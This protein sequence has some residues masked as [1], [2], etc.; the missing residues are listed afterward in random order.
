M[1]TIFAV[2]KPFTGHI[3]IIQRNAIHSWSRLHPRVEVILCGDE[4]GTKEMADEVHA[5]YLPQVARNQYGT[6]L[7]DSVFEQAERAAHSRLMCY[8]NADVVLLG[9]FATAMQRIGFPRFL[10]VGQ[11][12]DVD[13]T[14][15]WDFEQPDWE[16]GFRSLVA[17]RGRLHPPM[18]SDYFVFPRNRGVATLPPFAVGRPGWDNWFIYHARRHRV[19]VIDVTRVVTVIHQNHGYDHVPERRDDT[20]EGPEADSNRSLVGPREHVYVLSDASHV[21]TPRW[22]MPTVGLK[23]KRLA[24]A[25]IQR[26]RRSPSLSR[27]YHRLRQRLI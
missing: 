4:P 21:L 14:E 7:L 22:L 2:P 1:V 8:V 15:S 24:R 5:T 13:I 6:P 3:G 20:W 9:D 23:L 25:G 18:G 11:R 27:A 19:P 17:A 16:G 12:W 10:M 26:C